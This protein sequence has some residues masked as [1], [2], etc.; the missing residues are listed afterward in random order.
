MT[1]QYAFVF[2]QYPQTTSPIATVEFKRRA[3]HPLFILGEFAVCHTVRPVRGAINH[4]IFARDTAY[5]VTHIIVI[6]PAPVDSYRGQVERIRSVDQTRCEEH[7][8]V[9]VYVE[10]GQVDLHL[11]GKVFTVAIHVEITDGNAGY[12]VSRVL[13]RRFR[14]ISCDQQGC[15]YEYRPFHVHCAL[16]QVN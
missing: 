5:A 2:R 13:C 16:K 6:S 12:D 1:S 8:A 7:G 4:F 15:Q 3:V 9:G 11:Y 10:S 14:H